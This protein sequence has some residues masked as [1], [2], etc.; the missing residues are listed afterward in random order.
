VLTTWD[1]AESSGF[2]TKY[3]GWHTSIT[4]G[5]TDIRFAFGGNPDRCPPAYEMQTVSPNGDSGA[6]GMALIMVHEA[7]EA[8]TDPDL[9]AW[10]DSLGNESADKCAWKFVPVTGTFGHGARPSAYNWLIQMQWENSCGGGC[11]KALGGKFHN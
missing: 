6:D 7:S 8:V 4:I 11:D 3:C 5:G 10:Y 9:N 1:V 2:C